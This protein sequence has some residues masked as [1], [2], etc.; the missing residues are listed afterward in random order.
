MKKQIPKTTQQ[1]WTTI[2]SHATNTEQLMKTSNMLKW[3]KNGKTKYKLPNDICSSFFPHKSKPRKIPLR[4]LLDTYWNWLNTYSNSHCCTR[5]VL[6]AAE[7]KMT[8]TG[9]PRLG[10]Q[11]L[12]EYMFVAGRFM[13][14]TVLRIFFVI[15]FN[16]LIRPAKHPEKNHPNQQKTH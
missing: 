8:K 14:P 15:S 3:Q 10:S 13:C 12:F 5:L 9:Q 1:H 6:G 4:N 11:D 2:E 7:Q 16:N